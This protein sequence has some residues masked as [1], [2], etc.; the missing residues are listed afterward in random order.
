MSQQM[1]LNYDVVSAA[2]N[3]IETLTSDIE[4]RNKKFISLLQE[5][6][7]AT[8]G[9]FALLKTLQT[10]VEEEAANFKKLVAA[11]E[12]IKDS[13]ERYSNLAEEANDDSAFRG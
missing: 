5:K 11:Q 13:L 10:R 7:D 8:Q 3:R 2:V 1:S 6:N 4:T 12:E 9:K